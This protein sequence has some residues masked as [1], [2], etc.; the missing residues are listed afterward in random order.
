QG[1]GRADTT[2]CREPKGWRAARAGA[3]GDPADPGND[4]YY[5]PLR[6]P[7]AAVMREVIAVLEAAG[8]TVIRA[9]MPTR[10]WIGGPGT[11]A[12]IL[13]TNP[14]SPNKNQPARVPAIY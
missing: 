8:A 1:A 14:E 5:K 9:N 11:E 7:Q 6:P 2:K 3:P 13:N 10:G 4:V 12:A